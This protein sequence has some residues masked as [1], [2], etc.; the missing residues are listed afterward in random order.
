MGSKALYRRSKPVKPRSSVTAG[1]YLPI[2]KRAKSSAIRN[3]KPLSKNHLSINRHGTR[4]S[5]DRTVRAP[6][7]LR[8]V[9]PAEDF[10]DF[11]K[12]TGRELGYRAALVRQ[13]SAESLLELGRIV[14]FAY[15]V[16]YES[17]KSV[18]RKN[19]KRVRE[20]IIAETNWNDFLHEL[21]YSD[22]NRYRKQ[23]NQLAAIGKRYDALKTHLDRLPESQSALYALVNKADESQDFDSLL[24]RCS[25]DSTA[26]EVKK[27][28]P[29][30]ISGEPSLRINIPLFEADQVENALLLAV[31][32]HVGKGKPELQTSAFNGLV[33]MLKK[34]RQPNTRLSEQ[35]LSRLVKVFIDS[36]EFR[37]LMALYKRLAKEKN[38]QDINEWKRRDAHRFES[39]STRKRD[40]KRRD[41]SN[42]KV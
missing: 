6:G 37:G 42:L 13:R 35:K 29:K 7:S 21:G 10:K 19:K 34:S 30:S 33:R 17:W 26:A 11:S 39:V 25:K 8:G 14:N 1:E 32:L 28:F 40:T 2:E 22:F 5:T 16:W 15:E 36:D 4:G 20:A 18:G 12:V 23:I 3:D 38:Q 9:L 31:A 27:L 41:F 24:Q